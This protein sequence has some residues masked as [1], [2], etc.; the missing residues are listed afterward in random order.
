MSPRIYVPALK[1]TT[2]QIELRRAGLRA[3]AVE[4]LADS[5]SNALRAS[6]V[7]VL[8]LLDERDRKE[9]QQ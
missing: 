4:H 8:R 9:V 3:I 1:P 6:A 5:G 2:K 7:E